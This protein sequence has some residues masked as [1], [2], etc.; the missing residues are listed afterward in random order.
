MFPSAHAWGV[1][2]LGILA[3]SVAIAHRQDCPLAAALVR[4]PVMVYELNSTSEAMD[5][6]HLMY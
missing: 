5:A 3:A 4:A 6:T 1:G 2:W